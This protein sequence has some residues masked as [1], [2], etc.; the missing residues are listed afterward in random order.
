MEKENALNKDLNKLHKNMK[1]LK[2]IHK[3]TD[4]AIIAIGTILLYPVL[5]WFCDTINKGYASYYNLKYVNYINTDDFILNLAL[6]IVITACIRLISDIFY[7]E[8]VNRKS[9]IEFICIF[10]EI[11]L[12]ILYVFLILYTL[13]SKSLFIDIFTVIITVVYLVSI[14][15]SMFKGVKKKIFF[16]LLQ[17]GLTIYLIGLDN[18]VFFLLLF[19][20]V[21]SVMSVDH[22]YH[23]FK[24]KFSKRNIK[25]NSIFKKLNFKY[26]KLFLIERINDKQILLL[27]LA[28]STIIVFSQVMYLDKQLFKTGFKFASQSTTFTLAQNIDDKDDKY[29]V[30]AQKNQRVYIKIYKINEK[31]RMI[32]LNIKEFYYLDESKYKYSIIKDYRIE[33]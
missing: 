25:S 15:L 9:M 24:L 14:L 31:D 7:N 30:F 6:L 13:I 8:F 4:G 16:S 11:N 19:I 21:F 32:E 20:A 5:N 10:I 1:Y 26:K 2:K 33:R 23:Y 12:T 28:L 29:I 17:L 3:K 22:F 18:T 27:G